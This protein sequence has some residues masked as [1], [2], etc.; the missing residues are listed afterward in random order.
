MP[1][2]RVHEKDEEIQSVAIMSDTERL[3]IY[4]WAC[5]TAFF[6]RNGPLM[7]WS[8]LGIGAIWILCYGIARAIDLGAV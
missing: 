3:L 2:C 1:L 7:F 5:F 8:A 6:R 4:R